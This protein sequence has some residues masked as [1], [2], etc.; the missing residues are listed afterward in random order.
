MV[1]KDLFFWRSAIQS[2]IRSSIQSLLLAAIV[3]VFQVWYDVMW[4][5][6]VWHTLLFLPPAC[7]QQNKQHCMQENTVFEL[8]NANSGYPRNTSESW[9]L[10]VWQH[11]HPYGIYPFVVVVVCGLF[12]LITLLVWVSGTPPE[13]ISTM[14]RMWMSCVRERCARR[15]QEVLNWLCCWQRGLGNFNCSDSLLSLTAVMWKSK[16]L[17]RLGFN[18]KQYP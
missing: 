13:A 7:N 4:F 2:I 14:E 12:V 8:L 18:S 1:S 11:L 16:C 5:N 6:H 15:G 17:L 10:W 3:G 9:K